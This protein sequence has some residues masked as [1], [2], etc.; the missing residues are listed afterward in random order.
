MIVNDEYRFER[1][2]LQ[3]VASPVIVI[4][5]TLE[6]SFMLLEYI[7]STGV[8]YDHQNVFIVHATRCLYYKTF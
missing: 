4:L 1:M 7:Y 8:T 6:V 3:A 2:M 5:A